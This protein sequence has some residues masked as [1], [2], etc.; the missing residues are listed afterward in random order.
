M[1][2]MKVLVFEWP[3]DVLNVAPCAAVSQPGLQSPPTPGHLHLVMG[4]ALA[5][6]HWERWAEQALGPWPRASCSHCHMTRR[7][8]MLWSDTCSQCSQEKP[9]NPSWSSKTGGNSEQGMSPNIPSIPC[10][11]LH[12]PGFSAAS[13]LRVSAPHSLC[14]SLGLQ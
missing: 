5:R 6:R 4:F 3:R 8:W 13:Q 14:C 2:L 12:K 11:T 9:Q 10:T 1:A 7:H